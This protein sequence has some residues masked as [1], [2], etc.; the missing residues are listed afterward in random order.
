MTVLWIVSFVLYAHGD[1]FTTYARRHPSVKFP[2]RIFHIPQAM[3]CRFT[4]AIHRALQGI[5]L[6]IVL[7]ARR[8]AFVRHRFCLCRCGSYILWPP[9]RTLVAPIAIG[10]G[11]S[12]GFICLSA[13]VHGQQHTAVSLLLPHRG[14]GWRGQHIAPALF[15]AGHQGSVFC[16]D[17]RHSLRFGELWA[18][19]PYCRPCPAGF[20]HS[21]SGR[22]Q[23]HL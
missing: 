7:V 10:T 23:P 1:I 18:G 4:A 11:H 21:G 19:R 13:L 17:H 16:V 2:G 5:L 3:L 22:R 20:C 12:V 14:C 15:A 9:W 6:G 8:R